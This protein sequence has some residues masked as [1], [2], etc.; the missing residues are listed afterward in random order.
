MKSKTKE[1][2]DLLCR[3][4]QSFA[5][6]HCGSL[7]PCSSRSSVFS[8]SI[9]II[10]PSASPNERHSPVDVCPLWLPVQCG[11]YFKQ[12]SFL[13]RSKRHISTPWHHPRNTSRQP[14][15]YE[16]CFSLSKLHPGVYD[17]LSYVKSSIGALYTPV[18]WYLSFIIAPIL[19]F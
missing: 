15:F 19:N 7:I 6:S 5:L 11:T 2:V 14:C 8:L 12:L 17:N 16:P 4:V 18:I 1:E 10:I 13:P 3:S 9:D